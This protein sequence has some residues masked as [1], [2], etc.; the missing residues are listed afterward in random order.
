MRYHQWLKT[1]PG[2]QREW[3]GGNSWNIPLQGRCRDLVEVEMIQCGT[4]ENGEHGYRPHKLE[5]RLKLKA[6]GLNR[7]GH[8]CVDKAILCVSL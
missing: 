3:Q 1:S 7:L 6:C 5:S 2:Q 8:S 4:T